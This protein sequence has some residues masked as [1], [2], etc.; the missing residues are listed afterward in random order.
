MAS[1]KEPPKDARAV[2]EL[3][4]ISEPKL[5][6]IWTARPAQ[7]QVLSNVLRGR[8]VSK[9]QR[10]RIAD[11]MQGKPLHDLARVVAEVMCAVPDLDAE[12][13]PQRTRSGQRRRRRFVGKR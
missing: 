10:T 2:A 12:L 9:E 7:K 4:F 11:R 1:K 8:D 13:G 6:E 5:A 3:G